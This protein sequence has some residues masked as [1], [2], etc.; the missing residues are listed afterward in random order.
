MI[1][2]K[3]PVLAALKLAKSGNVFDLALEFG[4][5][6]YKSLPEYSTPFTQR[7][8]FS[9][10][11]EPEIQICNE[12]IEGSIHHGTHI[13]ALIHFQYEHR[14]HGDTPARMAFDNDAGWISHGAQTI[15]PIVC[16][17]VLIDLVQQA[18]KVLADGYNATQAEIEAALKSQHVHIQSGDAI[19]LR[20]GKTETFDNNSNN[21]DWAIAPG[22]TGEAAAWLCDNGANVIVIDSPSIDAMPFADWNNLAHIELLVTRGIHIIENVYLKQLAE[23]GATEFAFLCAP[24]K[25]QGSSGAWARPIAI[26]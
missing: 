23:S 3:M 18:G 21:A 5:Q 2:T 12:V 8:S 16:R 7:R 4:G 26:V 1:E 6:K 24:L 19:L 9:G 25:F 15:E 11:S 20:T 13:D 22:I 17:G 14:I 10:P